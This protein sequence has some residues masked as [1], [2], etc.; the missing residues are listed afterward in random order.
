MESYLSSKCGAKNPQNHWVTYSLRHI[1]L[2]LELQK[3]DSAKNL[4]EGW[5]GLG[6][7]LPTPRRQA[8]NTNDAKQ[9]RKAI[10]VAPRGKRHFGPYEKT[11]KIQDFDYVIHVGRYPR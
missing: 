6:E 1:W 9:L 11:G 2:S 5:E 8:I 7:F 10:S 3:W 4:W